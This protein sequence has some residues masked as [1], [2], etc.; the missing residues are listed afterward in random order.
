LDDD[1][2]T[3]QSP[4]LPWR[5]TYRGRDGVLDFFRQYGAQ[6]DTEF[7]PEELIADGDRVVTIGRATGVAK[8]TGRQFEVRSVHVWTVR[9]GRASELDIYFDS[10]LPMLEALDGSAPATA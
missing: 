4:A 8:T 2:V 7:V 3:T 10:P 1:F 9:D 6:V 5:G